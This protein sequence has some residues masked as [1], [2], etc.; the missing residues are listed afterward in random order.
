MYTG[1]FARLNNYRLAGLIPVAIC[2]VS[3]EWYDDNKYTKLAPKKD[4]FLEWKYGSHKGDNDYYIHNFIDKVLNKLDCKSVVDDLTRF[5]DI[6]KIVLLCYETPK[7][8]CH[9][10]LVA[11]WFSDNEIPC[12]EY[13]PP[14]ETSNILFDLL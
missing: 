5:G 2:G 14:D 9:R 12:S 10:H 8:F 1:Y 6:N 3:P 4:F 7:E 13:V 11:K